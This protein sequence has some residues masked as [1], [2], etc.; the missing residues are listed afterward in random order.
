MILGLCVAPLAAADADYFPLQSRK[1]MDL[2]KPPRV[3]LPEHLMLSASPKKAFGT[4]VTLLSKASI[5]RL[6]SYAP[7]K[8]VSFTLTTPTLAARRKCRFQYSGRRQLSYRC[9]SR[10]STANVK[11]R[12]AKVTTPVGSFDNAMQVAYPAANCADA[13]LDENYFV[14]YI[15]PVNAWALPSPDHATWISSM[16]AS[17]ASPCCPHRNCPSQCPSIAPS[18]TS[19]ASGAEGPPHSA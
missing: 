2:T 19:A 14:P 6:F 1:P 13:G 9:R 5:R 17:A 7:T 11:S 10:N 8:P 12:S 18:M 4:P 16:R 3:G 15:G